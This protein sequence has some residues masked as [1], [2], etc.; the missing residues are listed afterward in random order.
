[1]N[2][3]PNNFD[4]PGDLVIDAFGTFLGKRSE[5]MTVR[6][7]E[8]KKARAKATAKAVDAAT[9]SSDDEPTLLWFP[10]EPVAG[11]RTRHARFHRLP[12][13]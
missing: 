2:E 7:R 4:H 9:I 10:T 6:W 8:P 3:S 1:M 11:W 5:R 13:G 12:A